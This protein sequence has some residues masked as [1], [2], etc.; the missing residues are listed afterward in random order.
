MVMTDAALC[1]DEIG[2]RPI[3]VTE[4]LP[5]RITI[6][7][8]N[9]IVD[10]QASDGL[11]NIA[12]IPLER[13]FGRMYADDDETVVPV[14]LSPRPDVGQR[15]QA[16]DTIE[17]PEIDQYHFPAQRMWRQR[18]RI[19]PFDGTGETRQR[20]FDREIRLCAGGD[21]REDAG[22]RRRHRDLSGGNVNQRVRVSSQRPRQG[23]A[24]PYEGAGV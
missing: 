3:F 19:Q 18:R 11:T 20:A 6:V 12:D 23:L 10:L 2:R 14:F 16:I 4:R 21:L 5:D 1:I 13:E 7:D 8:G 24:L 17:G 9:G 15:M 22:V